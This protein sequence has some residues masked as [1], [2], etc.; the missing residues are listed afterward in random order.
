MV[1]HINLKWF[2]LEAHNYLK[3]FNLGAYINLN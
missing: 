1:A 3:W 2:N